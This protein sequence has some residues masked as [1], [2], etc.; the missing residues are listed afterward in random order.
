MVTIEGRRKAKTSVSAFRSS[1]SD[2]QMRRKL[3]WLLFSRL[4]IAGTLLAIVEVT[5]RDQSARSFVPVLAAV[6]GASVILSGFYFAALHSRITYK[7]QAYLQFS[8][9][10]CMVTW[11]VYR[12]GDIE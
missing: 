6:A 7:A 1:V 12:T 8:L 9:D 5:E 2:Q 11:L 3:Q 4:A 10:I